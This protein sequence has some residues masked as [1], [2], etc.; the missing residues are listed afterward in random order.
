M[1]ALTGNSVGSS[2]LGLLKTTDNAAIDGT[3]KNMTDGAGNATPL[4]MANNYVQLQAPVIELIEPTGGTNLIMIDAT[5]TLFEGAVDFTNASVTGLPASGGVGTGT[6]TNSM[7]TLLTNLPA[8]ASGSSSLALGRNAKATNDSS[9]AIGNYAGYQGGS[10]SKSI[11][12][13][14]E[15]AATGSTSIS[16]GWLS[17]ATATAGISLG[18]Q[19]NSRAENCITIGRNSIVDDAVR[20][21][22][23]VLGANSKSAQ[24]SQV[25][26]ASSFAIGDY[27]AVMGNASRAAGSYAAVLGSNSFADYNHTT[28][29]GGNTT[30]IN[31]T[32]SVTMKKLAL[33]ATGNYADQAAAVS[34][35]V[36]TNGVYH[37]DGVLKIVY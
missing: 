7:A 22:T 10:G 17:T 24:Y 30:A 9:I 1:A 2:Y 33:I 12:I 23:V 19:A 29:I 25:V 35:G 8:V 36:P 15:N 6:G 18:R 28:A 31:W 3:L 4:S 5:Q 27:C 11:V 21:D 37:T 16:M 34:A 26:G 14:S 13:G 20:V 32:D